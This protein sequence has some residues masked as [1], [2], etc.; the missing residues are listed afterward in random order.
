MDK[1]ATKLLSTN[2]PLCFEN[3]YTIDTL[4]FWCV[5]CGKIAHSSQVLGQV[6]R[7][8]ADTA[9]IR[10]S[11]HCSCGHNNSY[12]IRLKDD[13]SFSFLTDDAWQERRPQK[14]SAVTGLWRWCVRTMWF[15]RFNW[16][17]FWLKRNLAEILSFIQSP[18]GDRRLARDGTPVSSR[19]SINRKNP[20]SALIDQ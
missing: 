20:D 9:D 14:R 11:Y 5:K 13:K 8:V 7:L 1:T 16:S 15:L 10:A 6:S 12:R 3:G 18:S 4:A 19:R 2:F 17:C